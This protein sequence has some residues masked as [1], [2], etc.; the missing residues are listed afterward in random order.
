[1][2][3][4]PKKVGGKKEAAPLAR[5][6]SESQGSDQARVYVPTDAEYAYYHELFQG[7]FEKLTRWLDIFKKFKEDTPFDNHPENAHYEHYVSNFLVIQTPDGRAIRP[8]PRDTY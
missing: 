2:K 5:V 1:M 8:D 7:Y 3:L 4:Q 6:G